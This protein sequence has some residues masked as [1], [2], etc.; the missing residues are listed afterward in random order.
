M[1][2]SSKE[3]PSHDAAAGALP[4][5]L[6]PVEPPSAGFI[7]QLFVIPAV[8][9]AVLIVVVALFGKLAEGRQDAMDYVR[10][11]RSGNDNVRWRAAYDLASLIHNEPELA[12]DPQL[13]GELTVLLDQEL[14]KPPAQAST[15]VAQYLSATLGLFHTL[16]ARPVSGRPVDPLASLAKAL[17]PAQPL[18]VRIAAAESLARQADRSGGVLDHPEVIAALARAAAEG[19]PELRQRAVFA[20]GF[21]DGDRSSEI[22]RERVAEDEDRFVRYNAALALARRGDPA[23]RPVLREIL[24]TSDLTE[25]LQGQTPEETRRRVAEI[26]I[27][28]IHALQTAGERGKPDLTRE[29]RPALTDL[30]KSGIGSVSIEAQALLKTLPG[31]S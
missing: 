2:Q 23:A 8:I 13:L 22:L 20:L 6:P 10:A 25:A 12:E 16:Q 28:A 26:Q 14:A 30:A 11:I 29:F 19:D 9:V 17:G 21:I 27:E 5:E 18:P 15:E 3:P 7:L 31:S 1:S 4:N 24:S